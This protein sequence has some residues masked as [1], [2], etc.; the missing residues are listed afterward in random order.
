MLMPLRVPAALLSGALGALV[1]STVGAS[2]GTTSPIL[3][4]DS[5]IK[6]QTVALG[7]ASPLNTDVTI[8]HW[9]GQTFD[10]SN[11][12][13][14]GYNMA[15]VDP[16]TN[17]SVTI[18][19]DIIPLNLT[20]QGVAFNGTDR[21][22]AVEASPIFQSNSYV[23]TVA[24][25]DSNEAKGPGGKLSAGNKGVQLEDATMRAQFNKVGTAYHLLLGQ[26]VV[27]PAIDIAVDSNHGVL[28]ESRRGIVYADVNIQYFSA[29]LQNSLNNLSY[30]DPTH[31]PLFV[32]NDVVNYIGSN[33]FNCCVIGFHGAAHVTGHG[34]GG[35]N[36]NGNQG[37][38]TFAWASWMTAGFFNPANSW[39][40]QDI[41]AFSHEISEWADDPFV[42]NTVQPWL[43]PTA[44]QYGC[45]GIL[46]TGDPVVGIGFAVGSNPYD[47]NAFTDGM[48]HPED[49]VYLPWFTRTSPNTISQP[50]QTASANVGRYTFMGDLNP[51]PGFRTV[52]TGC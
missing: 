51:F 27:H 38:Q 26:P 15:G 6:A 48:Y 5:Q 31:L 35:V 49:E 22:P 14:Y 25:S 2:A 20:V 33:I 7:G 3:V 23:S 39:V 43:T 36:G 24:A 30:I 4:D 52:A 45:T 28:L 18:P 17:G 21:V 37:V 19:V 32:T 16:A 50:T 46:E 42:N 12:V 11:G 29:Q 40:L 1:A 13:T 10:P 34:L 9:F 8:P 41:N 44:P 47:Q